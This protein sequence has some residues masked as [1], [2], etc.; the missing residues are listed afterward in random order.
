MSTTTT[1]AVEAATRLAD[2]CKKNDIANEEFIAKVD[3]DY[4]LVVRELTRL[5][6]ALD[7]LDAMKP[8][9]YTTGQEHLSPAFR[10]P[11]LKAALHDIIAIVNKVLHNTDAN[12]NPLPE[13]S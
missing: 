13:D 12:G 8:E 9:D 10:T 6:A 11:N 1:R 3:E 4:R 5:R 7:Q 2:E